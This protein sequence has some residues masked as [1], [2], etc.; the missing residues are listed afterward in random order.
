MG[1]AALLLVAA[2][3]FGAVK[4]I[5]LLIDRFGGMFGA[6]EPETTEP[7]D[8]ASGPD[9]VALSNPVACAGDAVSVEL[10]LQA[11]E[12][13]AGSKVEV[14][15]TITNTGQVPC[16]LDVGNAQLT[17]AVTSGNDPI[18][19]TD[20]CPAGRAEHR[21]LLAVGGVQE[22][23]ITWSGRRGAQ[24]CPDDTHEAR[25]GT[26]QVEV[27]LAVGDSEATQTRSLTLK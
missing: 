11:T 19:S 8:T 10:G 1:L 6:S 21:I 25:K 12:V 13:D 18:W 22:N 23:T 24:D 26:Y 14:P 15:I 16:L 4:G 27:S 20:Q 17:M 7:S 9:E 2:V 3:A 5:P